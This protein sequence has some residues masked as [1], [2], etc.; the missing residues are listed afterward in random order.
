M[1]VICD[2]YFVEHETEPT[3]SE[4][5]PSTKINR[6]SFFTA[7]LRSVADR[8]LDEDLGRAKILLNDFEVSEVE[9]F[10]DISPRCGSRGTL[11]FLCCDRCAFRRPFPRIVERLTKHHALQV[12]KVPD[13]DE[14]F[15]ENSWQHGLHPRLSFGYP[16]GWNSGIG[17]LDRS[18]SRS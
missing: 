13:Q 1:R 10:E 16:P 9:G 3:V 6:R 7:S 4:G 5:I 18:R 8:T 2:E 15:F 12:Y 14:K 17:Q 11:L